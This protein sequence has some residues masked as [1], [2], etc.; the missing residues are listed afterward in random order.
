MPSNTDAI[1]RGAHNW[2]AS[3][4]CFEKTTTKQLNTLSSY[5]CVRR[6]QRKGKWSRR[7]CFV[8]FRKSGTKMC[9]CSKRMISA[10]KCACAHVRCLSCAP[11][12][13]WR[14]AQNQLIAKFLLSDNETLVVE[15][16]QFDDVP[17][18]RVELCLG[19]VPN[20]ISW[21]STE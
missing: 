13:H 21:Y 14:T 11:R 9:R 19:C 12:T 17:M 8:F 10:M 20:T 16:L 7:K 4:H 18:L 1:T 15:L 2:Y 3:T 5:L 6:L